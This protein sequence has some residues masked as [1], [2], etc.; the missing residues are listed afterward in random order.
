MLIGTKR[1]EAAEAIRF[2]L[3]L[4]DH[5]DRHLFL[6][7]W[8]GGDGGTL[9][10]FPEWLAHVERLPPVAGIR[11]D[12]WRGT[13]DGR[14]TLWIRRIFAVAG[15]RADLHK[16]IA[17]DDPDCFHTHPAYAIRVILF[18]GYVEEIEGGRLKQWRPGMI[19]I[20]RPSLCHRIHALRNR[21]FSL[22]L[23]IR[24][25]KRAPVRLRGG[26]WKDIKSA[27]RLIDTVL[28]AEQVNAPRAPGAYAPDG[29]R[30]RSSD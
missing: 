3:T 20:V 4:D 10:E 16:I 11:W 17:A 29:A 26:G 12:E 8:H 6:E 25:R 22:S 24:F 30:F 1:N 9:R 13:Q 7:A 21:R 15:R 14:P 18:G 27:Y 23:W 28:E 19:G 5:F 2:A